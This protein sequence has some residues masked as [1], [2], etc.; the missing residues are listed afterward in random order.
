MANATRLRIL[1]CQHGVMKRAKRVSKVPRNPIS[2]V[3][4]PTQ[5]HNAIELEVFSPEEIHALVRAAESE[6]DAA[7]FLT[8]PSRACA[9]ASWW[10]CARQYGCWR[11]AGLL[12]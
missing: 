11:R 2:D 7:I 6:Q 5:R 1:T 4:K 8:R 3:E 10:R 9:V 12:S